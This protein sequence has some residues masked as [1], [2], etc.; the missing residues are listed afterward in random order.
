MNITP[1][2][3]IARLL[4]SLLLKDEDDAGK[5]LDFGRVILHEVERIGSLKSSSAENVGDMGSVDVFPHILNSTSVHFQKTGNEY[6]F[7]TQT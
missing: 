4:T 3:G 1:T 7:Q 2:V 6:I 5:P